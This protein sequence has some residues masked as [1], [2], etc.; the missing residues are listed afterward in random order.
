MRYTEFTKTISDKVDETIR[1]HIEQG[2]PF[3]EC[4][5]R[6]GSEAFQLFYTRVREQRDVLELDWQDQELLETDIGEVLEIDGEIRALDV[7]Y[8]DLEPEGPEVTI[9]NYTTTHFYMCGSAIETAEQHADKPGM[10][11]LIRLQ[12]MIYKLERAV[13]DAGESTDDAKELAQKLHNEIMDAAKDIGIE[14]EVREYQT[15]HLNSIL[16]GDPEPGFGRVDEDI[17]EAKYRGR[18][19]KLNSPKRGGPKKFYVYVKTKKGN[20]K[21]LAFGASGMSVKTSDP[22][23]VRNFVA[24]HDCKNR[25][26]KTTASYWSCRLPRYKS[27]GIKGGQWW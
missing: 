14:Q 4:I 13:M 18:E 11:K 2:V 6:P 21:K 1:A 27:L 20:V 24:R 19:V 15:E 10:E 23:R 16:K 8:E 26:D 25:N 22:E 17:T 5:F 3:T 7:P 9:G 12:D